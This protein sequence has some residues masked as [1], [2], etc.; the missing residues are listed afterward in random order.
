M[1]VFHEAS[2]PPGAS[3]APKKS[4]KRNA[5][6][7]LGLSTPTSLAAI[8]GLGFSQPTPIQRRAIPLLLKGKDCILMSRTG[9]GKTACFLLPLLDLLGEHSSVVGVRA[10]L[11]APTRELVAQIHR[12]CS[13]LLHSSSLRVCCL[14]GGENY[15]KQFLALSRN[16]DVLLTTVGRGSQ[17]IHDKVLSLS[18]A[19]FLVLDEAD[20][21]FE[22][23]WKEQLSML[24]AALPASKQVVLVS[25]TLPGDLVNF[26]R[27]GLRDPEFVRLEKECT[28]SD[29][30]H[31]QFL[32]VR[33]AQKVPTLLFLLKQSIQKKEQV[34]VFA[35]TR[36]Q[37][38]FLQCFCERLAFPSAV[39]YGAMDQTERVQTL[40]AFKKGKISVLLVTDVA[41]RGLDIPHLPSVINFDFPSSAKLF[42]HRVGR[43]ARAGRSGTAF[44][45]VTG[46]DLPYAVELMS[47]LGGRLVPPFSFSS[48][49]DD[50]RQEE[51]EDVDLPKPEDAS[52]DTVSPPSS[53]NYVLAGP[54]ALVDPFV[55]FCESLLHTDDEVA[56]AH[57]TA[58]SANAMY[59]KTR[60]SASRQSVERAKGLLARC[61]GAMVLSAFAHPCF[62]SASG[63]SEATVLSRVERASD[64]G[65]PGPKA[66]SPSADD[67]A[68]MKGEVL[69]RLQNYRPTIGER[70]SVLSAT[71][72]RGMHSKKSEMLRYRN[73]LQ[74]LRESPLE[75]ALTEKR[76][77]EEDSPPVSGYD[78]DESDREDGLKRSGRVSVTSLNQAPGQDSETSIREAKPQRRR[79]QESESEEDT[80]SSSLLNGQASS[81]G[82]RSQCASAS[83]VLS[84]LLPRDMTS[85]GTSAKQRVSKRRLRRTAKEMGVSASSA[86]AKAQSLSL[87]QEDREKRDGDRL[88]GG[89]DE[90]EAEG[91]KRKGGF[92]LDLQRGACR[93]KTQETLLRLDEAAMDLIADEN[94]DMKRQRAT[95]QQRWDPK[96]R[97]YIMMKVD[98]ATG[99]AVKRKRGTDKQEEKTSSAHRYA[100]WCR[101]TKRRIQRVG[102]EE[103]P[104]L[105]AAPKDKRGKGRGAD[106]N[107]VSSSDSDGDGPGPSAG[108]FLAFTDKHKGI[109]EALQKGVKLTHKQKRIVKKL[110]ANVMSSGPQRGGKRAAA[111]T[112]PTVEQIAKKRRRDQQLR[113]RHDKKKAM[114]E[115]RKGKEKWMKRQQAKAAQKG[116]KN[117]S[118]MIVKKSKSQKRSRP[119]RR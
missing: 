59:Y 89:G 51:A 86:A 64:T 62:S 108:R 114:E 44:S 90:G 7:T 23:G 68:R 67:A 17:L 79:T 18:A 118:F 106:K 32:F 3:S 98:S 65:E 107:F 35:S 95:E 30:L 102:E 54:P 20:R 100:Q 75:N 63:P 77:E 47:F 85:E 97:K 34:L 6:E 69:F 109:Q 14:L 78:A 41:A 21:I 8:K 4:K 40:A 101:E 116:A 15:S 117:R 74:E 61:G 58:S 94:D 56:A 103:S 28:L 66:A 29:D 70:G 36:H 99:R 92:Y 80:Q 10:V 1:A 52:K 49:A 5:F 111:A 91:M 50:T 53:G 104:E 84:G 2:A 27:L 43:T 16:P 22:L 31:M 93:D 19:R 37:A 72:M 73:L 46:D 33:A 88:N 115:A 71:V 112:L 57:K 12:V 119:G 45:L 55:E 76:E 113:L 83:S 60:P 42:V 48:E 87:L 96:K 38:T 26:A 13:K 24:F 39:I 110:Q 81:L 9:S 11:I 82:E 25:A 105:A